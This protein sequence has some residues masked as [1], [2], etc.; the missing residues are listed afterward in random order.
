MPPKRGRPMRFCP[1]T[2]PSGLRSAAS[3]AKA[4]HTRPPPKTRDSDGF[5]SPQR[6]G[7]SPPLLPFTFFPTA[8][9]RGHTALGT[10]P[11]TP[12]QTQLPPPLPASQRPLSPAAG[13]RRLRE[14]KARGAPGAGPG[15]LRA[16]ALR[17]RRALPYLSL[18]PRTRGG[19]RRC[20]RFVTGRPAQLPQAARARG[21]AM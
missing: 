5:S 1:L 13:S 20:R 11:Y 7:V 8:P 19:R 16:P 9:Q 2:L 15:L 18:P 6:C 17:P 3:T 12:P 14:G 10:L 4:F 21:A